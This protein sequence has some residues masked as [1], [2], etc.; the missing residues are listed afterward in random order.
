MEWLED[1]YCRLRDWG[2]WPIFQGRAV[3]LPESVALHNIHIISVPGHTSWHIA[4]R[5][6]AFLG[7]YEPSV[8]LKALLN[9]YV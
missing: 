5:N 1:Y 2:E 4:P 9:P 6:K 7:A 3:K 8:S